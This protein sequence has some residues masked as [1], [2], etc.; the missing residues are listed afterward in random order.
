[1]AARDQGSAATVLVVGEGPVGLTMAAALLEQGL[2]VRI[3]DKAPQAS[4]KSKAL[5]VWSRTLELLDKLGLAGRFYQT[6]LAAQ[7]FNIYGGG[8]K[9][10]H[11]TVDNSRSPF[12]HPLMIPQCETERLLAEHLAARGVAVEWGVELVSL[13]ENPAGVV[14]TLR[15][16][17]NEE[18]FQAPWLIGCDGRTAACGTRWA[19]TSPA[20]PSPAN[21]FWPT[22]I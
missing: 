7:G 21:G 10:L 15:R 22:C 11:M 14:A 5:V 8:K 1:M 4:D 3:I 2:P 6:G 13:V 12:A 18:T 17:G 20:P 19:S 9:L 16:D